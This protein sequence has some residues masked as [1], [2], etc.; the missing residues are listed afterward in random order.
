MRK[1]WLGC[2]DYTWPKLNHEVAL[3]L[4]RGIGFSHVDVG[5]FFNAT[6]IKPEEV[7]K[8][9]ETSSYKFQKVM[10][11]KNLQVGDVFL[12]PAADFETRAPN[13]LSP[14][15]R[16]DAIA[17]FTKICEFTKLIG[18]SGVTVL[19]GNPNEGEN[20]EAALQRSVD[21]LTKYVN[22]ASTLNLEVSFEPHDKSITPTPQLAIQLCELVPGLKITL[23]SGHFEYANFP[24]RDYGEIYKY[25]RHVQLRAAAPGIM[26]AISSENTTDFIGMISKLFRSGYQGGF[27]TEYVWTAG[28][29]CRRVDN[30]SET[31]FL[32]E[33]VE[34]C[35]G[36]LNG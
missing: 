15:D 25:T 9:V 27:A 20:P 12:I 26:Q 24:V 8:D 32:K 16:K 36:D 33:L 3:N 18:G 2:A 21:M 11:E 17:M 35:I 4:I 7:V 10:S 30:V 19:P 34:S 22:I 31:I 23:D 14:S 5:L 28:W 29:E 1:N 13:N 6:H